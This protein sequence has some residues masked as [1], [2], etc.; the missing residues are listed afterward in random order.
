[1]RDSRKKSQSPTVLY[2]GMSQ[3][4]A[5]PAKIKG[6]EHKGQGRKVMLLKPAM[7]NCATNRMADNKPS[8]PLWRTITTMSHK[9]KPSVETG[10]PLPRVCKPSQRPRF[11][12]IAL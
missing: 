12:K 1:M 9:G 11:F 2:E 3:Y 6:L 4:A 10:I 5:K 8:E 7:R